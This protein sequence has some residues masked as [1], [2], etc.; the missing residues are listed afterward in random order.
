MNKDKELEEKLYKEFEILAKEII[1]LL[2]STNAVE[3]MNGR[4][5]LANLYNFFIQENYIPK[6]KLIEIVDNATIEELGTTDFDMIAE[7]VIKLID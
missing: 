7:E 3:K 4:M 1:N 5:K 6:D 2:E